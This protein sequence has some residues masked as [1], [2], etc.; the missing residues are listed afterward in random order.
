MTD[1]RYSGRSWIDENNHGTSRS[2]L[3][4]ASELRRRLLP[5][6]KHYPK[7]PCQQLHEYKK[8]SYKW[9]GYMALSKQRQHK[10]RTQCIT[11]HYNSSFQNLFENV[12]TCKRRN[13]SRKYT[14]R[15]PLRNERQLLAL[16]LFRP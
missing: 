13:Y 9:S 15:R 3:T 4:S 16:D 2:W 7:Q 5:P 8:H 10:R 6:Q 11:T 12:L 14:K 1:K